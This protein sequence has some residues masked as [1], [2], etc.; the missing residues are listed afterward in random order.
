MGKKDGKI[1]G[2][3]EQAERDELK[4]QEMHDEH[5]RDRAEWKQIDKEKDDLIDEMSELLDN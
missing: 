2:T 1:Q 3:I 5:E 4:M